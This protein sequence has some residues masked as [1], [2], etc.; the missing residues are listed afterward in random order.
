MGPFSAP[1]IP[2]FKRFK[3]F[4]SNV[5]QNYFTPGLND[6]SLLTILDSD[7][8]EEI[9]F[10]PTGQLNID[11]S[12]DDYRELNGSYGYVL[13]RSSSKRNKIHETWS[14]AQCKIYVSPDLWHGDLFFRI[15]DFV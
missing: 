14:Y 9:L 7:T 13:G 15:L 5:V 2:L 4:W 6:E 3:Q 8:Q 10:Y 12:R 11:H 1:E